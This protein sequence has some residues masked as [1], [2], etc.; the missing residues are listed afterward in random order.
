MWQE[1]WLQAR[2]RAMDRT[3]GFARDVGNV[4][5]ALGAWGVVFL[6]VELILGLLPVF[7][8]LTL[9]L[10]VDAMIG[11]RGIGVVTSDV[12]DQLA[13]W[14]VMLI[15]AFLAYLFTAR[16]TGK[17]GE[18]GR[19]LREIVTFSSLF[20]FLITIN[21]V[22]LAIIFLLILGIDIVWSHDSR[23][24]VAGLLVAILSA[25]LA[26]HTLVRYTVARSFTV[27]EGLAM[28]GG[29]AMVVVFLKLR[30]AYAPHH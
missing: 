16:F 22:F 19:G 6:L 26:A 23:V 18:V 20:V 3:I 30:I 8:V 29:I 13:R 5:Q 7:V 12:N 28:I 24:R 4:F 17:A 14:L 11:A 27:G 9:G 21:Q 15:V 25:S 10:T 1:F 2:Q